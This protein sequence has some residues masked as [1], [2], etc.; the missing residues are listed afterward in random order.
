MTMVCSYIAQIT[1][2]SQA[3][4]ISTVPTQRTRLVEFDRDD[5]ISVRRSRQARQNSDN[6]RS[7]DGQFWRILCPHGQQEAQT[8]WQLV[9]SPLTS[10]I[11]RNPLGAVL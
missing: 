6:R 9:V 3:K 1:T 4:Q 2:A 8:R 5:R 7:R 10:A 11:R